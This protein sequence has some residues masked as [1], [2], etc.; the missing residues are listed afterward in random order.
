MLQTFSIHVIAMLQVLFGTLTW[1]VLG[2]E[3]DKVN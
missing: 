3:H 1:E 2:A